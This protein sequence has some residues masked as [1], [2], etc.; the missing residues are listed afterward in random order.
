MGLCKIVQLSAVSACLLSAWALAE[1]T[2]KPA[3]AITAATQPAAELSGE[4]MAIFARNVEFRDLCAADKLDDAL[5]LALP[6]KKW[7]EAKRRENISGK[8]DIA[9]VDGVVVGGDAA[10]F[11]G[12][13]PPDPGSDHE[14]RKIVV[15]MVKIDGQ[16]L[17]LLGNPGDY[18]DQLPAEQIERLKE[19]TA[20]TRARIKALKANH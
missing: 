12:A 8:T 4:L 19:A 6:P 2:T 17:T 16:W 11:V 7:P 1:P 5:K 3:S 10:S 9:A 15:R 13:V 20:W 14:H 18:A